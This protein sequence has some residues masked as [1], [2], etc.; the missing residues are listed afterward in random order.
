MASSKLAPETP[1][2]NSVLKPPIPSPRR[3]QESH[4]LER[5][6]IDVSRST[7]PFS[8]SKDRTILSQQQSARV[9][10]EPG[11]NPQR[12]GSSPRRRPTSMISLSSPHSHPLILVDSPQSP[13]N[14]FLLPAQ[15]PSSHPSSG[16][17]SRLIDSRSHSPQGFHT[18]PGQL[19]DGHLPSS[20]E[21]YSSIKDRNAW[22]DSAKEKNRGAT[23]RED[24]SRRIIHAPNKP[25]EKPKVPAKPIAAKSYNLSSGSSNFGSS[26]NLLSTSAPQ[27]YDESP[28]LGS[29]TSLVCDES[30]YRP[31]IAPEDTRKS[32]MQAPV[33]ALIQNEHAS[34]GKHL[35]KDVL[36]IDA[37]WKSDS[38]PCIRANN[39]E[40]NRPGLPPRREIDTR[41]QQH[42]VSMSAP[43]LNRAW[44]E[45]G[46][47]QKSVRLGVQKIPPANLSRL[48]P[49]SNT[50]SPDFLPPPRRAQSSVSSDTLRNKTQISSQTKSSL[51]VSGATELKGNL[52]SLQLDID[53]KQISEYPDTSSVNRR[54]PYLAH[55]VQKIETRYDTKIFDISSR[56]ICT[57]GYLTKAWD[58]MS[59]G[60]VMNIG[61]GEKEI[62]ATAM[63][64]KSGLVSEEEGK[65]VWLGTNHGDLHEVDISTQ[66]TMHTKP[67]AHNRREIVKIFRCQDSMW[68]LDDDGK[69]Y[70]W[71]PDNT[72]SPN[73]QSIPYSRKVPKGHS[74]SLIIDDNLWLATGKDIRVFRPNAKEDER[75]SVTEQ[76]LSQPG[77]GEITSAAVIPCEPQ[78]VYFGHADGKVTTYSTVSFTCLG[79]Y[80]VSAYKINTLAGAGSYLWAGYST[81][82][83]SVYD[84]RIRPW[85]TKK[86]WQAHDH[87][88]INLLARADSIEKSG[89]LRVASIGTDNAVRMWDGLLEDDWL[90][91]SSSIR[92]GQPLVNYITELDMQEHDINYCSFREIKAKVL[93][94]NAGASTPTSLQYDE[95]NKNFFREFLQTDNPP[96]LLVFGFQELVDLEDKKLTASSY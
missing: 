70:V 69:L 95:R 57:T 59:G 72:G 87:P 47:N 43:K 64:F 4:T 19:H 66:T 62:R 46:E 53:V 26:K 16:G 77:V 39:L 10:R 40:G 17:S 74:Y 89:L 6:S 55:R 79:V 22:Q 58:L 14:P 25:N 85:S 63:A 80:N 31:S 54:P 67:A 75:F 65:Y 13:P 8:V 5:T 51:R 28:E 84:T 29:K 38:P 91:M 7:S 56:Y 32:Y 35:N 60:L 24:L 48:S 49:N 76:P 94:W 3:Q 92:K 2:V 30:N 21:S 61:H 44:T 50:T 1:S 11:T 83:I 20:S 93:T 23:S 15:Q 52:Y 81:G 45:Q 42:P 90:G 82:V 12:T 36:T 27:N 34:R 96:E 33:Y 73:L 78:M 41:L 18:P 86:E 9:S 68:T 88:V 71:P 37:I